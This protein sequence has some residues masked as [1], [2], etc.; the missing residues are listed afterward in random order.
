MRDTNTQALVIGIDRYDSYPP[1]VELPPCKND[2]QDLSNLLCLQYSIFEG[3]PII[4]SETTWEKMELTIHTFFTQAKHDQR[5]LFY[6]SGHA[7]STDDDVYLASP[8]TKPDT[9]LYAFSLK[10][11]ISLM[12]LSASTEIVGIIDACYSGAANINDP[13]Q[14]IINAKKLYREIRNDSNDAGIHLLLSSR[15]YQESRIGLFDR[16]STFTKHLLEGLKG[17]SKT[18]EEDWSGSVNDYGYVTTRSLHDYIHHKVFVETNDKQHTDYECEKYFINGAPITAKPLYLIRYPYLASRSPELDAEVHLIDKPSDLEA[19]YNVKFDR[20]VVDV[21][22]QTIEELK[23]WIKDWNKIDIKKRKKILLVTGGLGCG[24]SWVTF[25]LVSDL[26]TE[27]YEILEIKGGKT[28]KYPNIIS[29]KLYPIFILDDCNIEGIEGVAGGV[30]IESIC[31]IIQNSTDRNFVGPIIF[32]MHR[33][34]WKRLVSGSVNSCTKLSDSDA[35]KLVELKEISLEDQE[36]IEAADKIISFYEKTGEKDPPYTL[37]VESEIKKKIIE[38]S[39]SNLII[40]KIF[41]ER[42]GRGNINRNYIITEQDVDNIVSDPLYFI[43]DNL[44]MYYSGDVIKETAEIIAGLHYIA[45]SGSMSIGSLYNLWRIYYAKEIRPLPKQVF[46]HLS[47]MFGTK[48]YEWPPPL[49]NIDRYGCIISFHGSVGYTLIQLVKNPEKLIAEISNSQNIVPDLK[50]RNIENIERNMEHIRQNKRYIERRVNSFRK[51]YQKDIENWIKSQ[52]E[53]WNR[54]SKQKTSDD[55]SVNNECGKLDNRLTILA[56]DAYYF[57]SMFKEFVEPK[58]TFDENRYENFRSMFEEIFKTAYIKTDTKREEVATTVNRLLYH[59][60]ER[61]NSSEIRRNKGMV[62]VQNKGQLLYQFG[63]YD[64]DIDLML[65]DYFPDKNLF[66]EPRSRDNYEK[67][68]LLRRVGLSLMTIGRLNDAEIIYNKSYDIAIQNKDWLLDAA[69]VLQLKAEL[70]IHQGR[71]EDSINDANKAIL[72]YN[73]KINGKDG[74][75]GDEIWGVQNISMSPIQLV[76]CSLAYQAWALH[77]AGCK[78]YA[79]I[80]FQEAETLAQSLNPEPENRPKN[81]KYP[82]RPKPPHHLRDLWGI[83]HVD[84]LLKNNDKD[85]IELAKSITEENLEYAEFNRLTEVISQCYRVLGDIESWFEDE[86]KATGKE[87]ASSFSQNAKKNYDCALENAQKTSHKAVLIEALLGL[88]LWHIKQQKYDDAIEDYLDKAYTKLDNSKNYKFYKV[89][90]EI[91]LAKAFLAKGEKTKARS[92]ATTAL[93]TSKEINY[94]WG[95]VEAENL[96][97]I[98]L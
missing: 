74:S 73:E 82:N 17:V 77:L 45:E 47:N 5:L 1:F 48:P 9:L 70:Y 80:G 52:L 68:L 20:M 24:K 86:C 59:L 3:K 98:K 91:A 71:L 84:Y 83:Y 76:I 27:H 88:G 90:I 23:C 62:I 14:E 4:G 16:N 57:L 79:D 10:K 15:S 67:L 30:S 41:L 2:A 69:K 75:T 32:S 51:Q 39:K 34:T 29:K 13:D 54:E 78:D 97:S 53:E 6:F 25:K 37:I 64:T 95:K 42:L 38:K 28:D 26:F 36:S 12:K 89:D 55:S 94:Y 7:F 66:E 18:R 50:A 46:K 58:G 87:N 85:S 96:K 61:A 49:F 60:F 93:D 92:Y 65:E 43:L 56:Q 33:D 21:R 81:T 35:K 44:F 40:I 22:S 19:H 63:A 72:L 11:L 8:Q 31:E